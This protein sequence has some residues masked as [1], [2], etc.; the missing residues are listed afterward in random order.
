MPITNF[1]LAVEALIRSN[2]QIRFIQVGAN[3][4]VRFDDLF[5]I[6][7]N[8]RWQGLVIEPLPT[9]YARLVSNYQDHK[10]IIPI[11]IAIHPTKK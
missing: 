5:F 9:M 2:R 8:N 3:D 7:T 1:R 6:V 10:S 11:N 4:G